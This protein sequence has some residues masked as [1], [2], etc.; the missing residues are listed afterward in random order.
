[1]NIDEVELRVIRVP[2]RAPFKTSFG[3]E[4]E[5]VAVHRHRA[6]RGRRGLRRGRD[7]AAAAVPRG[8][9]RR[10]PRAACATRSC[11]DL[12]AQRLRRIRADLYDRWARWRGNQWRRPALELAVWD[13]YARQQ[14]VPLQDL[15]GGDAVTEIPVGASLGMNPVDETVASVERH[16]AEGYGGSS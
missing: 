11:P 7:G 3:V 6:Q 16:V 13:C 5:K 15:L 1:M 10:W 2:Y 4:T 8:D 14:G 12:L 9:A